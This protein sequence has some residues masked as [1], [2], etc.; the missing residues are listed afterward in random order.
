MTRYRLLAVTN[1]FSKLSSLHTEML[2]LT[3]INVCLRQ[4]RAKESAHNNLFEGGY[5]RWFEYVR[6]SA[7]PALYI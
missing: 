1:V 3:T 7:D 5:I 4:G 6:V 2:A